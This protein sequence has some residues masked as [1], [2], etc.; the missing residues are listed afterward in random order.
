VRKLFGGDGDSHLVCH[1]CA[2][3]TIRNTTTF[4]TDLAY[5]TGTLLLT[6]TAELV[7]KS[8]LFLK[9]FLNEQ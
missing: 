1:M 5:P 6:I 8:P 3:E 9:F 7:C 2:S 4:V